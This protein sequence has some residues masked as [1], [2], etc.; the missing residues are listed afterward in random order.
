MN[1]LA[2]H[3]VKV[4]YLTHIITS[5]RHNEYRLSGPNMLRYNIPESK[6][7]PRLVL[8]ERILKALGA[9]SSLATG[10]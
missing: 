9:N 5:C 10:A 4:E 6:A 2:D 1:L 7:M 8:L 3:K